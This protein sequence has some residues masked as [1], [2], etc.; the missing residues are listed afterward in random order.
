MVD[1]GQVALEVHSLHHVLEEGCYGHQ[2][3]R[4]ELEIKGDHGQRLSV[5]EKATRK[6]APQDPAYTSNNS[7][8]FLSTS[9]LHFYRRNR[10]CETRSVFPTRRKEKD[11]LTVHVSPCSSECL[12]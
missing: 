4:H 11:K 12:K 1:T 10:I 7:I 6:G 8:Q 9:V 5:E 2:E 3:G